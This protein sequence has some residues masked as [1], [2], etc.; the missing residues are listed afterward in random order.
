MIMDI[1][2]ML[3]EIGQNEMVSPSILV[4]SLTI[5]VLR[6]IV[7]S[8]KESWTFKAKVFP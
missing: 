2:P 1:L 5:L 6:N 4:E 7:L 3:E 8:V